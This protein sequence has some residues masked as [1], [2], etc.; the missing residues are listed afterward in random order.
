M[1]FISELATLGPGGGGQL[2]AGASG[3]HDAPCDRRKLGARRGMIG[4]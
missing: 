2:R 1:L 4:G 3:Q